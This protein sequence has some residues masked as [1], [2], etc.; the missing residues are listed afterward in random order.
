MYDQPGQA[1]LHV[2]GDQRALHEWPD[3]TQMH[4]K[5]QGG[6]RAA[7]RQLLRGQGIAQQAR[8]PSSQVCGDIEGVE[9]CLAQAGIVFYG[10]GRLTGK[11]SQGVER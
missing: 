8:P 3:H 10:I 2:H 11:R 7:L 6:G 9:P 4:I 5:G 1:L